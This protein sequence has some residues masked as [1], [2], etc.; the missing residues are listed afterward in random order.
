MALKGSVPH[1]GESFVSGIE[2]KC[3]MCREL[4]LIEDGDDLLDC[5]KCMRAR[6]HGVAFEM[7][8]RNV[9]PAI[10]ASEGRAAPSTLAPQFVYE[11][12]RFELVERSATRVSAEPE[13]GAAYS[14]KWGM[15][16]AR[17]GGVL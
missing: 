16:E 11:V 12:W 8:C 14:A 13:I 3:S 1:G 6:A 9:T 10:P 17:Y 15:E 4:R 7:V 2:W 5:P